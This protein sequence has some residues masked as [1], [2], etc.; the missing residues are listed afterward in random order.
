MTFANDDGRQHSVC[1]EFPVTFT[2]DELAQMLRYPPP[3]PHVEYEPKWGRAEPM[4]RRLPYSILSAKGVYKR[5][6]NWD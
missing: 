2:V 4:V 5:S 6:V 1:S 3:S